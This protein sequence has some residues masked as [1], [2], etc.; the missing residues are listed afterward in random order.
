MMAVQSLDEE[1]R[2]SPLLE[3]CTN[4]TSFLCLVKICKNNRQQAWHIYVKCK[5]NYKI[6]Y[7]QSKKASNSYYNVYHGL[8]SFS[9]YA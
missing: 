2:Y 1:A 9:E 5:K 3:N 7:G 8:N 4:Q 6:A